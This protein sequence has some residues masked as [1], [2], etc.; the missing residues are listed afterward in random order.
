MT[1]TPPAGLVWLQ[2]LE[3]GG[4]WLEALPELV[5]G[6]A[7]DWQ[8]ELGEPFADA[9]V[10]Y[11]VAARLPDGTQAVLKVQFPDRESEHEAAALAHW[12]GDG[13]VRLLAHDPERHALLLERCLPGT[14]LDELGQDGALD[15]LVGLLPRLWKPAGAPFRPLAEEA[16]WWA[17]SLEDTWERAGRTFD[18]ALLATSLEALRTLPAS[19]GEAVLL[20]QDLHAQNVLRAQREPWLVIDPK[21]LAGEREFGVAPIVRS[22]ELGHSRRHVVGRLDRLTSELALDRERA[23]LWSIAQTIAWSFGSRYRQHVETAR[24]LLEAED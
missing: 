4:A 14:Q 8:L 7:A 5:A 16:A 20:H 24:W 21:P 15:V 10:S 2:E 3:G 23:R 6:C 18:D 12:D 19:Q 11:A 17:E 13:A 9:H 1:A 22:L